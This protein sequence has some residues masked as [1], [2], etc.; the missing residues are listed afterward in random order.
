MEAIHAAVSMEASFPIK[1]PA[2]FKRMIC[3]F[4]AMR[5]KISLLSLPNT[6]FRAI[7]SVEGRVKIRVSSEST[8]NESQFR[9]AWSEAAID[10]E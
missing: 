8:E 7:E 5:P 3:P 6:R 9:I 2:G 1:M 10:R 4:E